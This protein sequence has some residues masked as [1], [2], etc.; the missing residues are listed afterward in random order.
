MG[1]SA[2]HPAVGRLIAGGCPGENLTAAMLR[3]SSDVGSSR[4]K[5]VPTGTFR[6]NSW[7]KPIKA[8]YCSPFCML[9]DH[10]ILSIFAIGQDRPDRRD[11]SGFANQ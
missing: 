2:R 11:D 1:E 6:P 10:R 8:N 5:Y 9:V 4:S 7:K 3:F